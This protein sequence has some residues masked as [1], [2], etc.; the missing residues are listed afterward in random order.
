MPPILGACTIKLWETLDLPGDVLD[1]MPWGPIL[2]GSVVS[3]LVGAVALL[4]L[5][6]MVVRDKL[7]YFCY[8]CW[9]LGVAV[10]IWSAI[11]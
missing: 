3:F 7:H 6:R 4:I 9:P 1:T 11:R 10:M 8:Y 5:L 2:A